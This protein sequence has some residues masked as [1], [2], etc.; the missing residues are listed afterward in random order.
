MRQFEQS[1]ISQVTILFTIMFFVCFTLFNYYFF[2]EWRTQ[3]LKASILA[4]VSGILLLG[5]V[6]MNKNLKYP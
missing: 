5:I 4:I 3:F 1:E 2:F 6:H